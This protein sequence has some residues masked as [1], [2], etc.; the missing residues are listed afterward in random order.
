MRRALVTCQCRRWPDADSCERVATAEDFLCD[1]CREASQGREA[2]CTRFRVGGLV[3]GVPKVT[4][5][6]HLEIPD[7]PYV[8]GMGARA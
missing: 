4:V 1:P 2:A 3:P 8:W 6:A 7:G 5:R